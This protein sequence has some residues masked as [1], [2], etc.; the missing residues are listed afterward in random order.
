MTRYLAP[1]STPGASARQI[2][3]GEPADLVL[4]DA[5][6]E[7]ALQTGADAVRYTMIRGLVAYRR[8]G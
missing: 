5:P 2:R 3:A 1:L 6:I 4:L 8:E 7:A